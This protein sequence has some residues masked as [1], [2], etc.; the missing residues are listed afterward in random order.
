MAEPSPLEKLLLSGP[1]P[2]RPDT[3]HYEAVGRFVTWFANAETSVHVLARKLSGMPDKKARIIFG[4]MRLA[5]LTDVVRAMARLDKLPQ[6]D[7]DEIDACLTQLNLIGSKRHALVHRSS[8]FFDNRIVV[9][10]I[11]NSK[12]LES[13]E[14]DAFT[15][16]QLADMQTDLSRIL[17]RIR[18]IADPND[19]DNANAIEMVQLMRTQPWLYKHIPPKP[20]NLKPHGKPAKPERQPRASRASR[21]REALSRRDNQH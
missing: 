2:I 11:Q 14:V 3:P 17:L 4:G 18:Y 10:N 9:T 1:P 16:D 12:S 15:V 7:Y 13:F 5:D 8:N 6:G 20:R 19:F 21:R